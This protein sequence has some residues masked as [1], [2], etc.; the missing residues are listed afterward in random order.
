MQ[1][2]VYHLCQM[3]K[4]IF[5][6]LHLNSLTKKFQSDEELA[7]TGKVAKFFFDQINI[8]ER[9]CEDWWAGVVEKVR[10]AI[11]TKRANVT[12]AIKLE[13]MHK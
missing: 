4:Q 8:P 13:F 2:E 7:Y 6:L 3:I 1:W 9:I 12:N 10:K 5:Y 11:D